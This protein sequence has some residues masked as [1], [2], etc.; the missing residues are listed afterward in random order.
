LVRQHA[1]KKLLTKEVSYLNLLKDAA[2]AVDVM[3]FFLYAIEE[4]ILKV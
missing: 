1:H 2:E 4:Q 3:P